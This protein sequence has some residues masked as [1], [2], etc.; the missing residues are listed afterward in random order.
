MSFLDSLLGGKKKPEGRAEKPR[1][2][3]SASVTTQ[4]ISREAAALVTDALKI[5]EAQIKIGPENTYIESTGAE[6][7]VIEATRKFAEAHSLHPQNALLHYAYASALDTAMQFKSAAEEMKRLAA[8]NPNFLLARFAITSG[9]LLTL[10]PETRGWTLNEAG[11][12]PLFT[13]PPWGPLTATVH[14]RISATVKTGVL[15]ATRDRLASRA[16]LFLRDDQGDFQDIQALKSARIDLTTMISPVTTP[17][18]AALYAKIWDNPRSPY[19]VE[20]FDLPLGPRGSKSRRVYEFLCLQE[21]IDFAVID[22][23]DRIL[24]NKRLSIPPA[25]QQTNRQILEL[26]IQVP[27]GPK[28]SDAELYKALTEHKR[29]I[30]LPG[31]KPGPPSSPVAVSAHPHVVDLRSSAEIEIEK[32]ARSPLAGPT[33]EVAKRLVGLLTQTTQ[34]GDE[35]YRSIRQAGEQLNSEGGIERM[36]EVGYRVMALGGK[37]RLLEV[38]WDRIG[39]W[40]A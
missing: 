26:L 11:S 3:D 4:G 34:K 12:Y 13:L 17:Q 21:D 30:P 27:D 15:V 25:M 35:A 20:A 14:P 19:Q 36:R 32:R 8:A 31:V 40:M 22:R 1:Q 24:L 7:K 33:E 10:R 5:I 38:I 16:T 39:Q 37:A 23:S 6:G 2:A 29:R 18:V 28:V 9:E